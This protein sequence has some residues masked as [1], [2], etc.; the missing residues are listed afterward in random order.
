[1]KPA[2]GLWRKWEKQE[3]HTDGRLIFFS[4]SSYFLMLLK[5]SQM[6][7]KTEPALQQET[8]LLQ[9]MKIM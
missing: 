9:R 2:V 3:D 5:N 8:I 1:M 4:S 7:L 6:G